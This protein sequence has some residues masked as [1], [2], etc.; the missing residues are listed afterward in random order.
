MYMLQVT[1][2]L[3]K[4]EDGIR[5]P[6]TGVI[7]DAAWS[8]CWELNSGALEATQQLLLTT[9]PLFAYILKLVF[10]SKFITLENGKGKVFRTKRKKYWETK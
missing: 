3:W 2:C 7:G 8:G 6:G 10:F 9:E 5:F 1:E 4:P